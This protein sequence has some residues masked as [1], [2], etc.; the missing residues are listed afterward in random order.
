[1]VPR[2]EWLASN[3]R[4]IERRVGWL[5]AKPDGVLAV[6]PAGP[7]YA[8]VTKRGSHLR[9]VLAEQ[10]RPQS[11]LTQSSLDLEDPLHLVSPY[12]QAALLGLAWPQDLRSVYAIGLGGGRV[13][14]VLHH[15]LPEATVDCAEIEP[16]VVGVAQKYFGL[17]Q[18]RRVVPT[19]P[20]FRPVYS[21]PPRSPRVLGVTV[22]MLRA[23]IRTGLPLL[24]VSLI[25]G[26]G[27]SSTASIA[28][29]TT[30]TSSETSRS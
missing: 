30:S 25:S 28:S 7:H 6:E 16:V 4:A 11:D 13:P 20:S 19:R 23:L 22:R 21:K 3:R 24:R 26:I 9:L 18:D 12:T 14:L 27:E 29:A 2:Q 17:R 1:M 5:Q 15:Y 10:T 8:V